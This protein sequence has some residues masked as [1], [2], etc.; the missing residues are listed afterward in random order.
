[1][2]WLRS[3]RLRPG[4]FAVAALVL[5]LAV[6]VWAA[7]LPGSSGGLCVEIYQND[8]LLKRLPL[9]DG[10]HETITLG[11]AVTN[12]VEIDGKSVRFS[13]SDCPDQV[14]VRTGTLTRAG[15]TAV[16][17]PN[18]VVVRLTGGTAEV[19]AVAGGTAG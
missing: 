14:C 16:C 13:A 19:D 4:D 15:Q 10:L 11:G 8:T 12:T 17:L 1:M 9:A 6:A 7:F 2:S 18:R 3:L 5:A